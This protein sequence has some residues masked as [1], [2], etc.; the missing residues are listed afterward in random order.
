M[1]VLVVEDEALIAWSLE[2]LLSDLGYECVGTAMSSAEAIFI[3]KDKH[4][5]MALVDIHLADGPTGVELAR[6]LR[7][8]DGIPVIF[9]SANMGRIPDD[10]AGAVGAIGK[11]YTD[12]LVKTA[13][14][15]VKEGIFTPPPSSKLPY[16]LT[17]SPTYSQKWA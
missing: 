4:P 5:D 16:G 14:A 3:A 8:L 9:M 11:P 12:Q 15:Y 13:L 2:T 1:K 6:A 17:L 7:E 10:Y